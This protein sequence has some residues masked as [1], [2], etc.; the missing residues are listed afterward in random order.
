M[1]SEPVMQQDPNV[2][3]IKLDIEHARAKHFLFKARLR[4]LLYGAAI[5]EASVVSHL[6]CTVGKWIYSRGLNAYGDIAEMQQLEEVHRQLHAEAARLVY[7]YKE[8]E[9]EKARNGLPAV[10]SMAGNVDHLLLTIESKA[11]QMGHREDK[12]EK[13]A[14]V[15]TVNLSE[16]QELLRLNE[17]LDHRIKEQSKDL[18]L[19]KE[20]FD[21]VA[22][23][24]QDAIWDWNLVTNE[25]WWNVGYK[26]LF[27]YKEE[28]IETH[29]DS[30]NRCIHP[31]DKERV[32][33]SINQ[34]IG[35]GGTNWA[36]EYRFRRKDGSYAIVLDRAYAMQDENGRTIRMLGSMQDITQRKQAEEGLRESEERLKK[37][38]SIETVGVIYFDLNGAIHD[39]NDAFLRMSGYSKEQLVQSDLRWDVLTPPEFFDVTLQSK[40]ELLT[41]GQNTPYEKQ[42]IRPDGSRWWGLFAGKRLSETECVEFVLDITATKEIEKQLERKVKE[43]TK[44]LESLNNQLRLTNTNLEE[45][46]YAASHDLKEPVRK[47]HLFTDRLKQQ[48]KDVL[49]ETQLHFFERMERSAERMSVLIDDLL[50]YSHV[51][52]GVMQFESVDLNRKVKNVQEDLE[53]E[54]EEKQAKIVVDPLPVITG[55]KRQ[56]QQLFQNLLGNALKYSKPDVLPEIFIRCR[57]VNDGEV[58]VLLTS[59]DSGKSF[60]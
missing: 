20:R 35:R 16:L 12:E 42:Y 46:A 36:A 44:D 15:L 43:R 18:Y 58:P 32:L 25:L 5:D 31:D 26:E 38:L 45:F 33:F 21:L 49:N 1:N 2:D 51:S 54:I 53:L 19:S 39:A 57:M 8:G 47:I 52:R 30:W 29:I 24:T 34:V 6:D 23:A 27:G 37:V 4:S 7:W 3:W 17:E 41:K 48:L 59:G 28:D 14:D 56:M 22:K 50:T 60:Y 40:Q 13:V 11:R 55:H 9:V 10:E